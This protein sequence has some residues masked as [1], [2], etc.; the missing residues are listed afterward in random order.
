MK[1]KE[2]P[3]IA[4]DIDDV[5]AANA[6]AFI[7]FSNQKFGTNLRT[8]DYHEHWIELW[9]VDLAEVKRRADLYHEVGHVSTYGV[10]SGAKE[11]LGRLRER[12]RL[13]LITSR[14]KSVEKI[15]KEWI[16]KHFQ[17]LF[18]DIVFAGFF[19]K[20][21]DVSTLKLTKADIAK[22]LNAKYLIDDQLKHIEAAA[23]AGIECVLFGEYKW[24][25]KADL[26]KGVT[27]VLD[28]KG[29]ADYFDKR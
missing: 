20:N 2:K 8:E 26:P 19:D 14:R 6:P 10:I 1:A 13:V 9:N 22:G 28:W 27:R 4:I 23:A 12:F 3:I 21:L 16:D 18:E 25:R 17:G 5:I 11:A 24:N 7:E 15:T 29:V